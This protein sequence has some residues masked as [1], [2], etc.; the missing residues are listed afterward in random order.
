MPENQD[1]FFTR[2]SENGRTSRDALPAEL[3][4]TLMQIADALSENPDCSPVRTVR[5]SD[6]VFL[7][8]HP[9]PEIQITYSIDRE[10]RTLEFLHIVA[11][12]AHAREPVFISYSHDDE[13]WLLELKKFLAPLEKRDLIHIWHDGQIPPGAEWREVIDKEM[14]SA[15]AAILLVS[16]NFLNS[17]FISDKELPYLLDAAKNRELKILWIAVSASTVDHTDLKD[18]QAVHKEP[19][20]DQLDEAIRNQHY[21][22]IFEKIKE[23]AEA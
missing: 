9:D 20:L 3:K 21:V 4:V 16:Q 13:K 11:P 15:K 14:A 12:V 18:Y 23:V 8:K 7:Y 2:Y 5:L 17:E 10:H 22:Q 19:P 1:F 6:R